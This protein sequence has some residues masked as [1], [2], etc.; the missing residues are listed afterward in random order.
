MEGIVGLIIFIFV[1]ISWIA[2]A[3]EQQV[4]NAP[5]AAPAN[6]QQKPRT[7]R[8]LQ[9]EIESFLKEVQQKKPQQE[10]KQAPSERESSRKLTNSGGD[11]PRKK[12]KQKKERRRNTQTAVTPP[13]QPTNFAAATHGGSLQTEQYLQAQASGSF[14]REL[15]QILTEDQWIAIRLLAQQQKNQA[16]SRSVHSVIPLL[17]SENIQ[18]SFIIQEIL[19]PPKALRSR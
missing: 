17:N 5:P 13:S 4:K 7:E 15:R 1:V 6:Q 11:Q 14:S 10:W 12:N 3:L 8:R 16:D 9:Q 2:K 18:N 19:K